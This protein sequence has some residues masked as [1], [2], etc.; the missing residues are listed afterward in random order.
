MHKKFRV[1]SKAN[2]KSVG[3]FHRLVCLPQHYIGIFYTRQ[4]LPKYVFLVHLF[5]SVHTHYLHHSPQQHKWRK[6]WNIMRRKNRHMD[7]IF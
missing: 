5:D 6:M 4:K 2:V 7:D 3:K 1:I